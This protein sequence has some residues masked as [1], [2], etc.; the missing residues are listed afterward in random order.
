MSKPKV[1]MTRVDIPSEAIEK[2]KE[3]CDVEI[4]E[5]ENPISKDE[6]IKMVAGKDGLYCLLTDPVDKDVIEAAGKQL[7]VIATMSVGYEHIDL[8]E[9]VKRKIQ[10]SNTPDVSSD[11]V[12]EWTV[13]LMLCA[14][15]N[16]MD[17][18][19]V[20]KRG[21]WIHSWRPMW[22]CGIGLLDA[23]VGIVGMGRIGQGVMKRILPFGVKKVLYFDVF[24]P[25]KP[26]EEMGAKYVELQELL[27]N[28]DFVVS[29][30]NLTDETKNLFNKSAFDKMKPD[31][32]FINTSRGG[33]VNQDDLY[34]ALK[35]KKIRGAAL[36]V[37]LPEPLPADHKLTTLP[38][39][40]ITPHVASAETNVRI[41]M[42][43]LA[44]ENILLG[45]KGEPLKTPV[46]MPK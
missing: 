2:V 1:L 12:A 4:Y 43:N 8:K 33:V 28:S 32:V 6:L 27:Q 31:A 46:P 38:N 37:T 11:S 16:F 30:C 45:V 23:T 42:G 15:R 3:K 29:M 25:I 36:D 22:L 17:A 10:V 19:T 14:G 24:H 5:K 26:A 13:M 18:A 21:E 7:K 9:C 20:I 39:I 41:K 34:D 35:N 44:A 40:I